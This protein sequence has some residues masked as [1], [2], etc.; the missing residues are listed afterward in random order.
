MNQLTNVLLLAFACL[1]TES[2]LILLMITLKIKK[3]HKME[4]AYL[5]HENHQKLFNR[6]H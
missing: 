4:F 6:K 5:K 2:D 3:Y 1:T